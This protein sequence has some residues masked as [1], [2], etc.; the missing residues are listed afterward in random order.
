MLTNKV[1]LK[2]TK[3]GNIL[4]VGNAIIWYYVFNHTTRKGAKPFFVIY[5]CLHL[6][7]NYVNHKNDYIISAISLVLN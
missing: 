6:T 4:K 5:T 3:R 1:F 7:T 2:K